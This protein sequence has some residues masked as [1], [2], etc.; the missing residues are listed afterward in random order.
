MTGAHSPG[1]FPG[2]RMTPTHS[3]TQGSSAPPWT[4]RNGGEAG[5]GTARQEDHDDE[6]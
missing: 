3:V 1:R 4:V 5:D 6:G 2:G